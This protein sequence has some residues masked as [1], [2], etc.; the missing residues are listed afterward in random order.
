M[1]E[2]PPSPT[3]LAW[4]RA[5]SR[6]WFRAGCLVVAGFLLGAAYAPFLA[7][8]AAL[9]WWDDGG[10]HAPAFVEL[11]NRNAYPGYH[12]LLF[13]LLAVGLPIFLFL[14]WRLSAW[15]RS[16]RLLLMLGMLSAAFV[17]VQI[18]C[19]P[20]SGGGWQALWDERP[21]TPY[22]SH[23]AREQPRALIVLPPIPHRWD[24]TYPGAVL[25][26][27]GWRNPATGCR[28]W[29]GSDPAGHD[30]AA[31]L[32]FGARISLTIGLVATGIALLIGTVIGAISGFCGGRIDLL[33]QRAVEI[34]LCFPTFLLI[35]AV[36]AMTSRDIFVI[37]TVI[38][39][40]GWAG[41]ARLVRGEFLSQSVRDYV[42]AARALG[43]PSWRIMFRHVLPNCLAP[44]LISATFGIAGAV[45]GES[46]LAFIGLGD[47]RAASWGQL[48]N[49][50]RENPTFA[51]LIY[52]PGLAIFALVLALNAIGEGLRQACDPRTAP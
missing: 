33:L 1:D 20:R 35:L 12:D 2:R 6:P 17:A 15:R 4:R 48:L 43:L 5:W 24:A 18:P 29:L 8:E 22:T 46:G 41:T 50:G 28:M 30:V 23:H 21:P 19:L 36:V 10:L 34:M 32:L 13:N 42:T 11:F 44:L 3:A 52:A 47:P 31:R 16:R 26:P 9:L 37:M 51:W 14:W 38:G 49:Y 39:L 45:L 7:N 27:P 40:T 25:R